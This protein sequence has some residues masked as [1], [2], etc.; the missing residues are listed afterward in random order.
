MWTEASAAH[1]LHEHEHAT[2]AAHEAHEEHE[3]HGHGHHHGHHH[4]STIG[5]ALAAGFA[6]MLIVDK[7]SAARDSAQQGV[8]VGGS[9][10]ESRARGGVQDPVCVWVGVRA[11]A[12]GAAPSR[13][14]LACRCRLSALGLLILRPK[15][16][17]RFC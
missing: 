2:G 17:A 7:I 9:L 6:F 14:A 8:R 4:D 15:C 1:E 13:R 16:C 11:T 3:E 10:S 5:A 12:G